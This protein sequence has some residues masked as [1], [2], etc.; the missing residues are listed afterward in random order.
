MNIIYYLPTYKK[1]SCSWHA[2]V[3][4]IIYLIKISAENLAVIIWLFL[5]VYDTALYLS[6]SIF[7]KFF[8]QGLIIFPPINIRNLL[9]TNSFQKPFFP[10]PQ[11]SFLFLCIQTTTNNNNFHQQYNNTVLE[12]LSTKQI[13]LNPPAAGPIYWSRLFQNLRNQ[14]SRTERTPP[15]KSKLSSR[16][17]Q[18]GTFAFRYLACG[19]SNLQTHKLKLLLPAYFNI[20]QTSFFA[21][22]GLSPLKIFNQS[23]QHVQ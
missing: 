17:H 14:T 12:V 2:R 16:I 5:F 10:P 15:H 18:T 20:R 13:H 8:E 22:Q 4:I 9:F 21:Y 23:Y 19:I 7:N 6:C 1:S 11:T 3:D